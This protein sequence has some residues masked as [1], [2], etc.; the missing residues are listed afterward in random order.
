MVGIVIVAHSAQLAEG[1]RELADQM[2][3]GQVP[4][5]AAGGVDD[6]KNPFGT[7]A[8]R[9]QQAIE[10]VYSE[11][12]VLVLM[13]LGSAL[14][15]AEMAL[16]FLSPEQRKHVRLCEAPL[17]EG[18]IAAAVQAAAGSSLEAVAAEAR[19]ALAGKIAQLR[20]R[21]PEAIP[22]TAL[23][24]MPPTE[25]PAREVVLT[26]RNR[27]GLHARPAAL[28]VAT[29]G[30]YRAEI[31]VRNLTR[32]TA[33]VS[34]KS[35]NQVATLGVRQG[36][37][38]A[39]AAWGEDAEAA[40]EALTALVENNFGEP[41]E[42]EAA[43][44][45]TPTAE[46]PP[47]TALLPGQLRGIPA[48]PGI[49]IGPAYLYEPT[50]PEVDRRS[51]EDPEAEVKRLRGAIQ[52]ARQEIQTL[53]VQAAAQVGDYEAAIFD[54]HLLFLDDPALV[55]AAYA[56]IR[57]AHINA[58]AAWQEAVEAMVA[59]Y[60]A[61]DDPYLQA[62]AGD[63]ADVGHRVLRLLAGVRHARPHLE[64]PGIL[65]AADLTPSDT[66][67]LDVEKVLGIAT[68]LGGATSHSAI[69][70]RALGIPAVVGVGPDLLRLAPE[71]MLAL[72]GDAGLIHVDPD[73]AT[74]DQFQA[75]RRAW[76]ARQEAARA[77]GQAPAVT[78]DGHRVEVVANI[79]GVADARVALEYGAEGVGLLRTEFLYLDRETAPSEEEQLTAYRAI[80]QVMG[81]RPLIIRTLDVGGD[82]PIPYLDLGEE[83]NPFL[84]WRG[85]RLC[86]DRPEILRTQL[87]AILRA[88]PDHQIKVMFPMVSTVEEVRAA[89][90]ILS[91]AQDELRQEGI[92]FDEEMEVGIMIE[93]PAAALQA[94]QLAQE[95][96]FFSIGTNDLSQYTMAADR[97]NAQVA[98]LADGLQ[99]AVLRLIKAVIDA[100]HAAGIWVGLCGELAGD[101][102]AA[103]VL[104]GLGL[105]EFS[106]N[107][108]AI[109][110]VK[111]AIRQITRAEAQEIARAVLGMESAEE[112]RAYL[113]RK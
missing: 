34:A 70:A 10:S 85:I 96:D 99:P 83:T 9:V 28:F 80:A 52:T 42:I 94:E 36:H 100:A 72:D 47:V 102:L 7:D 6:P 92:P 4:L 67:Q 82:K 69:L 19:N 18:A 45:P 112:V 90:E 79:R 95:V 30:R 33:P 57:E 37:Q 65:I 17:V 12:G 56:R 35:I 105:D 15:S 84:G 93:V 38:I 39:I 110:A 58:E 101:P 86:L 78:L 106:M 14:L 55:E 87:R 91:Q 111:Q 108:P 22:P 62:R 76:L 54:A 89:R 88:S 3:Q 60:Q 24:V 41:E 103:P 25:A 59:A 2:V 63:V 104:L 64:Q 53:R 5:A 107:P 40:L 48:S 73:E 113:T 109:P 29:A 49:A 20:D 74:L 23:S 71:T 61:L 77:A 98:E 68:A 8:L 51:V 66:A 43:L 50:L 75:R 13:D 16:D 81:Q 1:V 27:L 26:V 97:T 44:P 21:F 46:A 32:Q 11:D 31:T